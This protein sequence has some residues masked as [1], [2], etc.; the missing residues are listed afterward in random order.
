M[1]L[2]A[3][4]LVSLSHIVVRPGVWRLRAVLSVT[5]QHGQQLTTPLSDV[6]KKIEFNFNT[7][8]LPEQRGLEVCY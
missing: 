1:V 2:E 8:D 7:I 4:L 5:D 6:V 3:S